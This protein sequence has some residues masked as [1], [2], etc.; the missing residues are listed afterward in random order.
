MTSTGVVVSD[1]LPS[2]VSYVSGSTTADY[3]GDAAVPVS[4]PDDASPATAF[5]LDE[6]GFNLDTLL[7]LL[8]SG[9][10]YIVRFDVEVLS[11]PV[12]PAEICNLAVAEWTVETSTAEVCQPGSPNL[13]AVGDFVWNDVNGNGIQD[14]GETGVPGVTVTVTP[15]FEIID[16][17]LDVDG[18]GIIDDADTRLLFNEQVIGGGID[19]NGDGVVDDADDG[20]W[21]G[22]A[23]IDGLIDAD[24]DGVTAGDSGDDD[25]FSGISQSTVTAADGSWSISSLPAGDYQVTFEAAD[26]GVFTFPDQGGDDDLDSDA[27]PLTGRT[28][29][30]NLAAGE[31]D[32]SLDAGLRPFDSIG[33]RVWLDEDGDGEQ[34]G[35]EA[36]VPGVTV[37]LLDSSGSVVATTVTDANGYYIFKNV[38]AGDYTVEIDAPLGMDATYDFDGGLDN[39]T[40]LSLA[41][42]EERSDIDFG[43][44]WVPP[45]STDNP[46]TGATGAIGDRIWN[47]ADGNGIQDPGE[48]GIAGVTVNLYTDDDGTGVYDGVY[49]RL[50][51]TATT[52]AYGNY[53]FDDL[54][55][56]AYVVEVDTTTLPSGFDT[57]PTGEPDGDGD[58]TTEPIP[59]PP[60]DVYVNADFG[61][62][63]T[64][65]V[66]VS[67][68][69]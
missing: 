57:T 60:G 3:S 14:A 9:Q 67:G 39:S 31:T 41:V 45:V 38:P 53:I 28:E 69:V 66:D 37:R 16:G 58:S 32:Y 62:R 27:D 54:A 1:V 2:E 7:P 13:G 12:A 56:G 30:F 63:D 36:G 19:L 24:G 23:V 59:L 35:G 20:A 47:D 52:D 4:V 44:N 65:L 34:D 46:A 18:N 42:G 26:S 5:P 21:A 33:D 48:S 25:T 15:I 8:A 68:V 50:V 49:D 11:L 29:V 22:Y 43:L 61:Y 10:E 55:P 6:S 64:S 51:G 17:R 40:D